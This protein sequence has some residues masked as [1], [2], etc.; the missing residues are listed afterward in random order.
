MGTSDN[1][2]HIFPSIAKASKVK[3]SYYDAIENEY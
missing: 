1:I 3:V 2:Y